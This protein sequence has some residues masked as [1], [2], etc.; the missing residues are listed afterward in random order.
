LQF[1][2]TNDPAKFI[3]ISSTGTALDLKD[4]G[5]ANITSTVGNA[6]FPAGP[7]TVANN[8][9]VLVG[10]NQQLD[11]FNT[12]LPS[13]AFIQALLPFWDDVDADTG[14]VYWEE[15]TVDGIKL[16]IVQWENRP[17]FD[18]TGSATF[19]LQL[20]DSGPVLARYVYKDVDFGNTEY[21]NGASATI[22]YQAS[23]T[24]AIEYSRDTASIVNGDVLEFSYP[25]TTDLDQYQIDLTG[26]AGHRIDIVLADRF[27]DFQFAEQP[28]DLIAPDGFTVL[29]TAVHDPV[30]T[31]SDVFNYDLG[32]LDFLVPADGI[33]TLRLN[34]SIAG[35]Y[36]I[37][38][39][40]SAT[41]DSELNDDVALDPLRAVTTQ[42]LGHLDE[43]ADQDDFYT[44]ELTA[45]Q[46]VIITTRTPGDGS[47]ITDNSLDPE[48]QITS[49]DGITIVGSETDNAADGK[50]AVINLQTTLTGVYTIRVRATAGAG[51]YVLQVSTPPALQ[52]DYNQN[53]EVDAADYVLWRRTLGSATAPFT[54]AD[55]SGNGTIDQTDYDTWTTGFGT[56]LPRPAGAASAGLAVPISELPNQLQAVRPYRNALGPNLT[57]TIA[58]QDEAIL[59][60]LASTGDNSRNL[61]YDDAIAREYRSDPSESADEALEDAF[62]L[63][64]VGG[65]L[66]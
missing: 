2:K 30:Q 20:F 28:L 14:N 7:L 23:T 13:S 18:D 17:H 42:A 33:Y 55:G 3:D 66:L 57:S 51:E 46:S 26:K 48:L 44:V 52:G 10:S 50:N 64:N 19:Q 58:S 45:D 29:A 31:D 25:V 5:T 9:G 49:P 56:A 11:Y 61:R 16:L 59:A 21:N 6:I 15:Q 40:D 43:A 22:G 54:G 62:E 27:G 63:L 60:W 35:D 34:S 39:T 65:G 47:L 32:I 38:V 36:G 41:F 1:T 53:G 37:V 8:G 4:D 12:S 24:D